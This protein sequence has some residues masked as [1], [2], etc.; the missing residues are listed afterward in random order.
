[1]ARTGSSR[2]GSGTAEEE[3]VLRECSR[4]ERNDVFLMDCPFCGAA[5]GM[6]IVSNWCCAAG[7]CECCRTPVRLLKQQETTDG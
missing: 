6:M 4:H 5:R 1:M 2:D 3:I 7:N